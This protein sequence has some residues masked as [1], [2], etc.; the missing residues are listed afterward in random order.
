MIANKEHSWFPEECFFEQIR[1]S[2]SR[3]KM[4][5]PLK[6]KQLLVIQTWSKP[7]MVRSRQVLL[8]VGSHKES[9]C[10]YFE[11]KNVLYPKVTASV[12]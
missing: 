7:R 12:P 5:R 9:L 6:L 3:N 4:T 11:H 2:P 10:L 8:V 1:P